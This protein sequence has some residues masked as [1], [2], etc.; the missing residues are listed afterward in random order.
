MVKPNF[1]IFKIITINLKFG[2]NYF[3]KIINLIIINLFNVVIV[4]NFRLIESY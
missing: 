4:V 3:V 1:I 2:L